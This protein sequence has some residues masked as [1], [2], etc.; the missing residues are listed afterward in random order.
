M[1]SASQHPLECLSYSSIS[2][3]NLLG[4]KVII[5]MKKKK[6]EGKVKKKERT[7]MLN[8]LLLNKRLKNVISKNVSRYMKHILFN[9]S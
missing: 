4:V 1:H 7:K 8:Q 2:V 9:S 6:K 3:E 5:R